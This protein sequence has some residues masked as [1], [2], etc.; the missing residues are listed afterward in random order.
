[1]LERGGPVLTAI[2]LV[3]FV[4]W[5]LIV[6]R[7]WF[8][9]LIHP[10]LLKDQVASWRRRADRTSWF[11]CRLREGQIADL[12][13]SLNRNLMLIR[14]LVA[15]L[16]LLGLLGTVGGMIKTFDVVV[17]F[18]AANAHGFA[19]GISEALLTTTVG[20]VTAIPGLYFV[21]H[22]QHWARAETRKAAD[23]LRNE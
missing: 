8:F 4:T 14:T 10:R 3:S 5:F 12:S 23:M 1:M 2:L 21:A 7:Y 6:E 9:Y 19:A 11:A 22:L 16:P 20:L 15:V 18:G 17:A 13:L